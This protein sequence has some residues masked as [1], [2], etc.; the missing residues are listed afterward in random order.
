M[1]AMKRINEII[2]VAFAAVAAAS[3]VEDIEEPLQELAKD[4][5]SELKE[6]VFS[7]SFEGRESDDD[8]K[9]CG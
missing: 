2:A 4:D 6:L 3:C 8:T 9:T 1:N 5:K 7:A